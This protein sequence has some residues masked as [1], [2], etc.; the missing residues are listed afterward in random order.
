MD[1]LDLV[2]ELET[3]L[4]AA[5]WAEGFVALEQV[6]F[7]GV[8]ELFLHDVRPD[9]VFEGLHHFLIAKL[10]EMFDGTELAVQDEHLALA[11]GANHLNAVGLGFFSNVCQSL[12][13][14]V[15][16]LVVLGEFDDDWLLLAIELLL[17]VETLVDLTK[18][19]FIKL[20][21]DHVAFFKKV[22]LKSL[23]DL[24]V[25]VLGSALVEDSLYVLV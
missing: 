18:G 14:N 10:R 5:A 12:E 3:N 24:D 22:S 9:L 23:D 13:L 1:Q 6:G 19:S 25:V 7:K 15:V 4:V 17:D 11:V 2:Q 8:T 20:L 21:G 16:H